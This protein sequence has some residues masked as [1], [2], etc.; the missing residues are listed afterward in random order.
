MFLYLH[1]W[2]IDA[3]GDFGRARRR[4]PHVGV[5]RLGPGEAVLLHQEVQDRGALAPRERGI[6]LERALDHLDLVAM[7]EARQATRGTLA[8][9]ATRA[10]DVAPDA[11][12]RGSPPCSARS[13]R[14]S[15]CPRAWQSSLFGPVT[16]SLQMSARMAVLRVRPGLSLSCTYRPDALARS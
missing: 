2:N 9:V 15:R 7:L 4:H 16:T 12:A 5:F 13:R 14:R 1:R 8:D 11:R 3:V 6:E 10:D